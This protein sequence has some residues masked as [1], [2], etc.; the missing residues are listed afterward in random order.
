MAKIKYY[1]QCR[2]EKKTD[3]GTKI[4][5]AWIPEKFAQVDRWIKLKLDGVWENHWR[6][7]ETWEKKDE[8]YVLGQERDYLHQRDVSDV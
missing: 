2:M 1:V 7:A 6:V 5:V 8:A 3:T 4:H